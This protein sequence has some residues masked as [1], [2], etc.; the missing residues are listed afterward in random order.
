MVQLNSGHTMPVVGL[1]TWKAKPGQVQ[2]AVQLAIKSGYRHIDAAMC[3]KNEAEVGE[4]L[5]L[6]FEDV[7]REEVF[8]TSKL[9]NTFHHPD[10][11]ELACR[12]TLKDLGKNPNNLDNSSK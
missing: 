8:V 1:G 7:K 5:K 6:A 9:W 10:H 11:V 3:Y 4:G 2:R 12:K